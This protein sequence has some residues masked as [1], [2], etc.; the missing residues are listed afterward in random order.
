MEESYLSADE[1]RKLMEIDAGYLGK[2]IGQGDSVCINGEDFLLYINETHMEAM[3]TLYR[4][5]SLEEIHTLL[6]ENGVVNGIK[7]EVLEELTKGKQNYT[8]TIVARG[9]P[10]K[11]GKDGCFEY[12]FNPNP[13]KGPIILPDDTVDYNV[14]GKIELVSAGQ[15][16]VT[17]HSAQPVIL[18]EDVFGNTVSAYEGKSYSRYSVNTVRWMRMAVNIMLPLRDMLL[19]RGTV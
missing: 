9:I 8:E 1:M 19:L 13:P 4:R 10:P 5:F 11:D 12:H 16:L 2:E 6:A 17:Y 3:L 18:G 7:E 15:L 14:L